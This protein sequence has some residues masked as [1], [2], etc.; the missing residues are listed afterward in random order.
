MFFFHFS[1]VPEAI[2]DGSKR[3]LSLIIWQLSPTWLLE[4]LSVAY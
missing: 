4:K 1:L 2:V 3:V